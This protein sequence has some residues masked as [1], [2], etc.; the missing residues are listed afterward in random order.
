MTPEVQE[1]IDFELSVVQK[2]GFPG[3]FLIVWDFIEKARSMD[4]L[5][6]PGRGSAAGSVVAYC[7]KITNVDPLKYGL[8]FERFLNPDRI[9]MPD[10]DIDFDDEGRSKVIDYVV[11]KYGS[12]KVAQIVTFGSMAA[13]SSIRDVARV[14]KLPLPEADRLAKLIP[15]GPKVTL[16]DAF[17]SVPEL[18]SEV[19]S[20][21]EL[22]KKTLDFAVRLE[23]NI[24]QTG[25]HA[26]GII[27]SRDTLSNFVPIATA[28][29]SI[30]PVIQYEGQ[31]AEKAGL[32]KMDF[33]GLKT[34]SI[35]K[36]ALVNI[37]I[38]KGID[39][40]IDEIPIDDKATF[41]VFAKGQTTSLFQF[42]S[43][44]MKKHLKDL[45]PDRFEDLIAMNALFRPGPMQY[46]P[47]YINRKHKR[48][49]ID[50][51]FPIMEEILKETYGV[52]V[53]QEQVMLLSQLLAGFTKGEAD[54]LRKA[55]GKK[56]KEVMA[57]MRD[58]F[59]SGCITNGYEGKKVE[60]IWSDWEKFAEYAFNKSHSTCYAMLAYQ[61]A[62]LKAHYPAEYMAA[63]LT[64]NLSDL[65]KISEILEECKSMGLNVLG[66]DVNESAMKFVVPRPGVIR[67]GLGAV[68]NVGEAAVQSIIETRESTPF[69]DIFDFAR[70]VNLRACNKRCFEALA[71]SGAFDSF[72]N[73][74][75]AQYLLENEGGHFI[76]KLIK[77]TNNVI[78][79]KDS[80]QVSLFGESIEEEIINPP[81]PECEPWSHFEQLRRE[82]A[83]TG[84][85]LSGHPL[86]AY[87]FEIENFCNTPI[88]ALNS[89]NDMKN[90]EFTIAGW[91]TEAAHKITKTGKPYGTFILE[92]WDDNCRFS[93]F[94]DNYL[95]FKK[96]L[97][98]GY[99][100]Y[101]KGKVEPNYQDK[102]QFEARIHQIQML[103]EI[104]DRM[105]RE[106]LL[107]CI[108][109]DIT[110]TLLTE[111]KTIFSEHKGKTPVRIIIYDTED[112]LRIDMMSKKHRISPTAEFFD[113]I[114]A[115]GL[116]SGNP[117][118][119]SELP[120]SITS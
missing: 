38:S 21:K 76:D 29:D 54:S 5:V 112:Q 2:M 118:T 97:E 51:A 116:L 37:K 82:K 8:L 34:L 117:Y 58:K 43:A 109:V 17:N 19:G 92:D 93:L 63:T 45:Q 22:V 36:D 69:T 81:I 48:E 104:R 84:F 95:N 94:S 80:A 64:H 105:I 62:Y 59:F 83:V 23:G 35:L 32:L 85:F 120:Y 119:P 71:E 108:S 56:I 6:G 9:S 44:G 42:E 39:I 67:F 3:Y 100:L 70:R 30:L 79:R 102:T 86:D 57:Q 88:K 53:Y 40:N 101:V 60:Q 31:L 98:V 66:P 20:G 65:K 107:H 26:C 73:A 25:T 87:R 113:A 15:D 16:Q 89:P 1:R 115:S 110:E 96:F 49:K 41:E 77:H 28:K 74:N 61:T 111:L 18:Q 14:L 90:A 33:L 68:K 91:V 106:V 99:F 55:M 52:T 47:R 75:R 46:I 24:R 7:L 13:K 27:I 12:D 78:A 11:D 4:V 114:E 72:P 10:V 103:P 50:Y